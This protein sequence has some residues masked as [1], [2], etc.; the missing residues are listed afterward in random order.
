MEVFFLYAATLDVYRAL[1]HL[2]A[3]RIAGDPPMTEQTFLYTV[4]ASPGQADLAVVAGYSDDRSFLQTAYWSL[5]GRLPTDAEAL[6]WQG[7]TAIA[8]RRNVLRSLLGSAEFAGRRILITNLP[9]FVRIPLR[10]RLLRAARSIYT[11]LP[12]RLQVGLRN[13]YHKLRGR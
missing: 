10:S 11:H 12:T 13:L 2:V 7:S 6:Q 9:R 1:Y 8:L 3:G 4:T 5:L